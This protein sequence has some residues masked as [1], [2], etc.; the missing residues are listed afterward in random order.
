MFVVLK[1]SL[2]SFHLMAD[3]VESVFP[4][5]AF[6]PVAITLSF[7]ED[8]FFAPRGRTNITGT[9]SPSRM[10]I[11]HARPVMVLCSSVA[12]LGDTECDVLSYAATSVWLRG[13]GEKQWREAQSRFSESKKCAVS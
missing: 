6:L 2:S 10:A 8:C 11:L 3:K 5:A 7:L 9:S 4:Q 13:S 1:L 12:T